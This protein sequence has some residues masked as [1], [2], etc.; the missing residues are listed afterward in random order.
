M[1]EAQYATPNDDSI[2]VNLQRSLLVHRESL[3]EPRFIRKQS[4]MQGKVES[5]RDFFQLYG[6]AKD[7][8]QYN[9]EFIH[10]KGGVEKV[11]YLTFLKYSA[12]L[13]GICKG[14]H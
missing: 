9:D 5:W 12:I 6:F 14:F 2:D 3:Y 4:T 13:F 1:R 8:W 11:L 10:K 7:I